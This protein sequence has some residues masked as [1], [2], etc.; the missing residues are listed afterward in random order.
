MGRDSPVS[1]EIGLLSLGVPSSAR[2]ELSEQL[3]ADL[4]S[5]RPEA[6]DALL[7]RHGAEVHA[8]AFMI[9]R[10]ASDAEEVTADAL[11]TAWRK[12]GSLRDPGRL[13]PWLLR[14]TTRLALRQQARAREVVP[15]APRLLERLADPVPTV[16]SRLVLAKALDELPARMR[17]VVVLHHV[18]GLSVAEVAAATGRS[19]NT[20]KTQLREA[21]ARLRV[22]FSEPVTRTRT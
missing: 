22:A 5:R 14:I 1:G 21:L 17:A 3:V 9:T 4:R 20:V 12:I 15:L 2:S 18:A 10:N 11:L 16:M 6:L 13:R 8:V 19:Q 7:A